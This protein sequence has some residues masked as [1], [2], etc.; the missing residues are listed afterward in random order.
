M[1]QL[2]RKQIVMGFLELII[3]VFKLAVEI[4]SLVSI[5]A[6]WRDL[7]TLFAIVEKCMRSYMASKDCDGVVML[8]QPTG[9]VVYRGKIHYCIVIIYTFIFS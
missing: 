3:W 9:Q 5:E 6:S 8:K 2:L 1:S 7:L 4:I